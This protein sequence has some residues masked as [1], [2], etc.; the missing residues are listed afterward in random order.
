MTSKER[1]AK[2][3]ALNEA[4]EHLEMNWSDDAE[5]RRQGRIVAAELRRRVDRL[6]ATTTTKEHE[7]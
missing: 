7:G 6:M 3:E 4:A 5:E 2:V 1:D